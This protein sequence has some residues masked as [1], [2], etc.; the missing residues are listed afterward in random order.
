VPGGDAVG[1]S[2]VERG[3][4]VAAAARATA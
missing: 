1:R 2:H 4:T 3:P